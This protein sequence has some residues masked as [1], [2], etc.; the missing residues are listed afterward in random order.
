MKQRATAA[1]DDNYGL[2]LFFVCPGTRYR[3]EGSDEFVCSIRGQTFGS[4]VPN[5]DQRLSSIPFSTIFSLARLIAI[6]TNERDVDRMSYLMKKDSHVF[7]TIDA[8]QQ[9]YTYFKSRCQHVA[10][11]LLNHNGS[12]VALTYDGGIGLSLT[13][14]N[15]LTNAGIRYAQVHS[16]QEAPELE[17]GVNTLLILPSG[18]RSYGRIVKLSN[19]VEVFLYDNLEGVVVELRG[20]EKL[21]MCVFVSPTADH[22]Y[23][24]NDW[25][26]FAA[27]LAFFVR[28]G[29]KAVALSGPRGDM[30]WDVNRQKTIDA[31]NIVRDMASAMKANV[32]TMLST[33]PHL[34][35]PFAS[36]GEHKKPRKDDAY[37]VTAIKPF[38]DK[39]NQQLAAHV[40]PLFVIR[41]NPIGR[42]SVYK[43]R[44]RQQAEDRSRHPIRGGVMKQR[45]R[46]LDRR[47]QW[48]R[49]YGHGRFF[50]GNGYRGLRGFSH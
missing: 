27:R 42:S 30:A 40:T 20:R 32:I 13:Q 41:E 17:E 36:M 1:G 24:Q 8:V 19:E 2:S 29:T 11:A 9:A 23:D 7:V 3:P 28:H 25:M 16:W 33:I 4:V 48:S 37:P 14:I 47:Q 38:F 6:F 21:K 5:C 26:S 34:G 50:R 43:E 39:L 10:K 15:E 49:S 18:F 44:K 46:N 22:P 45:P 31:F 12:D 35:E